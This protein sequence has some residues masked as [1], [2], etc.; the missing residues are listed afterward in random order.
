MTVTAAPPAVD[1]FLPR[2][3]QAILALRVAS[4]THAKTINPGLSGNSALVRRRLTG[5][6][7]S[8]WK[9][10]IERLA[11]EFVQGRAEVDPRDYPKTCERCGLQSVCRIQEPENRA[12][13][14]E[15]ENTEG[16]DAAEE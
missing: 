8:E 3:A 6:D 5:L 7:E 4:P 14:E 1:W 11:E 12:R 16:D 13:V 9:K 2:S 15:E 10:Y